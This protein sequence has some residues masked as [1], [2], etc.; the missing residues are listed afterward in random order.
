MARALA[1]CKHAILVGYV[2]VN[3]LSIYPMV[4]NFNVCHV[5]LI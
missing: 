1:I 4:R 5:L 2:T 3:K